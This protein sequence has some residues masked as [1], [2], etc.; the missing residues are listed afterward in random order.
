MDP[1]EYPTL[2]QQGKV[3]ISHPKSGEAV[4]TIDRGEKLELADQKAYIETLTTEIK[5]LQAEI[6]ARELLIADIEA[7]H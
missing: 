7:A 5:A 6:D 2:K 3:H 1:L 4:I